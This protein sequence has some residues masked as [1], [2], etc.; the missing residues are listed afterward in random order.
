MSK[1]YGH[2]ESLLKFKASPD[3]SHFIFEINV[4]KRPIRHTTTLK[5]NDE[6]LDPLNIDW[7]FKFRVVLCWIHLFPTLISKIKWLESGLPLN[8]FHF[9]I[10]GGR[11]KTWTH[12]IFLFIEHNKPSWMA[13]PSECW[14]QGLFDAVPGRI[15]NFIA[16]P[17][18]DH[19]VTVIIYAIVLCLT[20][21]HI[22]KWYH[23]VWLILKP[24]LRALNMRYRR[25][26]NNS[27]K[28]KSLFFV[29]FFSFFLEL[30]QYYYLFFVLIINY[31]YSLSSSLLQ[32]RILNE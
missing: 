23:S 5:L 17:Y 16:R 26:K 28:R 3:P 21:Q 32:M 4:G 12:L 18:F 10:C 29:Q 8:D 27:H 20:R 15:Q 1:L 31:F 22:D 7:R 9:H 13:H 2:F 6:F 25:A 14:K 11:N 30:F 19:S 24:L